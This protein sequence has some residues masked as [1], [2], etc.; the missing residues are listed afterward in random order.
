MVGVAGSTRRR[1]GCGGVPATCPLLGERSRRWRSAEGEAIITRLRE[2]HSDFT[3]RLSTSRST[4]QAVQ[5]VQAKRAPGQIR[6]GKLLGRI[7]MGN[8][9]FRLS[10]TP[11][12]ISVAPIEKFRFPDWSAAEFVTDCRFC[13]EPYQ[14]LLCPSGVT[15][16]ACSP[17]S[18]L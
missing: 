16:V 13:L 7:L 11:P 8:W 10:P 15:P 9:V 5:A 18:R 14:P 6:R 12:T 3:V 1:R 4:V 17:K 2:P